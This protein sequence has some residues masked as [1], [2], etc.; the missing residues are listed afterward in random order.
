MTIHILAQKASS[1]NRLLKGGFNNFYNLF[2]QTSSAPFN[3]STTK[4]G[5]KHDRAVQV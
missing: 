5:D 1:Y 2:C 4:R 3:I